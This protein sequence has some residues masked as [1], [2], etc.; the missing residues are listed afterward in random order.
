M[1]IKLQVSHR[2]VIP[3]YFHFINCVRVRYKAALSIYLSLPLIPR[4]ITLF[5][6]ISP[7]KYL[8]RF[9][10]FPAMHLKLS[11]CHLYRLSLTSIFMRNFFAIEFDDIPPSMSDIRAKNEWRQERN[12]LPNQNG[13]KSIKFTENV[14]KV[15]S[16]GCRLALKIQLF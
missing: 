16:D 8:F 11:F 12:L 13:G 1:I 14:S 5:A 3:F 10:S 15:P 9:V 6:I 4:L 7:R 2:I